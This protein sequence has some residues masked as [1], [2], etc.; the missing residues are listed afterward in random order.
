[1]NIFLRILIGV[2]VASVG[3]IFVIK[4]RKM[5]DFFGPIGWAEQKLGGGGSVL[6]YKV[7][8]LVACVIGLIIAA[9]LWDAFLEATIG[10]ITPNNL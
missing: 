2:A 9:D 6:M 5:M 10:S 4:T 7:I 8:G 3:A 1:M